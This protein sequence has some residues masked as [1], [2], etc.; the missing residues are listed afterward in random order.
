MGQPGALC[1]QYPPKLTPTLQHS[2]VSSVTPASYPLEG[3]ENVVGVWGGHT[4]PALL[5]NLS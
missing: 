4:N 3:K 5:T 2:P 1:L